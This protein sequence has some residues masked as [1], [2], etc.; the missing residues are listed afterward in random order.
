MYITQTEK[1]MY[2]T[3]VCWCLMSVIVYFLF[4][5]KEAT[6]LKRWD[7]TSSPDVVQQLIHD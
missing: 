2:K 1:Y 3:C 5:V 7:Y 6:T 4:A